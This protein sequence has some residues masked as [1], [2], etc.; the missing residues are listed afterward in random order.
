VEERIREDLTRAMREVK[1]D[2]RGLHHLLGEG[3]NF[4]D[5]AR[6]P[7][8]ESHAIKAFAHVNSVFTGD[9]VTALGSALLDHFYKRSNE[10]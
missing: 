9:D 1:Y 4:S 8:F 7:V 3:L 5:S 6:S 10:N 2:L